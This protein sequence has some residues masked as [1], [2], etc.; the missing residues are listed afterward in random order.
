[1]V[2]G[3]CSLGGAS[4]A[5]RL[6]RDHLPGVLSAPTDDCGQMWL[7]RVGLYEVSRPKEK[8]HDRVW[9][10]DHTIQIG[11]T[12][13]LL[14]VSVRSSWWQNELRPLKHQDLEFLALEPMN[15]STGEAVQQH[16]ERTAAEVGVPQSIV[17]DHGADVRRGIAGFQ[18]NHAETRSTYD[19]AHKMAIL[20]KKQLTRDARWAT[21]LTNFGTA[22]HR[23]QQTSLAALTPPTPK[24][25]ARYMNLEILV[26]WGTKMLAY[27]D[28][29][30]PL[31]EDEPDL[32][33]LNNKLGW[34]REYREAL[35]EW[36]AV[37]RVVATTLQYI[38]AQGYHRGAV[39]VL[40]PQLESQV[41]GEISRELVADTLAFVDEQASDAKQNEHLIGSS[42]VLE[43]IIGRGKRME[44]QQSKSGFTRMVLAM[45]ATVVEPTMHVL[46]LALST[47]NTRAVHA[48][49][50]NHLGTS[51]QSQRRRALTPLP[52]PAGGT[53]TG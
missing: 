52:T 10:V 42:E 19:I 23:L 37:I 53:E 16:L 33:Q 22:R 13:C 1:M 49:C 8:T 24:K 34:L 20:V 21:Y 50:R 25:K 29:P 32:E 36:D 27:L 44:Q 39:S 43:S 35:T 5:L 48:W 14:I 12:K 51:V 40:K 17:S 18:E 31:N 41:K 38:R 7:L 26:R 28:H 47:V 15:S 45:A 9:I 3:A 2:E 4:A 6:M 11:V 46:E 30:H